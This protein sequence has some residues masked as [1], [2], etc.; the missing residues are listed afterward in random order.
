VEKLFVVEN[1]NVDSSQRN[2]VYLVHGEQACHVQAITGR[3]LVF[4]FLKRHTS[5]LQEHGFQTTLA[6]AEGNSQPKFGSMVD[7]NV[8]SCGLTCINGVLS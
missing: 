2:I 5:L 6:T 7:L 1:D 8:T 4:S 3:I